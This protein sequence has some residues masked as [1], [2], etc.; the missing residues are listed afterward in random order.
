[1]MNA[2]GWMKAGQWAAVGVLSVL[3]VGVAEPSPSQPSP[4]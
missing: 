1:M 3:A 2:C 4:W